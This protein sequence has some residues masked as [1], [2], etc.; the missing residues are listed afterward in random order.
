[1]STGHED[2]VNETFSELKPLHIAHS[3]AIWEAATTGT[4]EATERE[5]EAQGAMMRFW[6]D[7]T[8][9]NTADDLRLKERTEDALLARQIQLIYLS[10]AKAQQD[11]ETIEKITQL[12]SEVRQ[13]YYN[14]R[15]EV[16][17][18][19]LT[20]NE[21][22][23]ILKKSANSEDVRKA[24]E[25]GKQIGPKV[26]GQVRD[27]ARVRNQ[28][29]QRQGY[30][31]HFQKSLTLNEIDEDELMSLFDELEQVTR[32]PF[33]ELKDEIDERRAAHFGITKE[34]LNPWH[35]ADSFF[36]SPP[37]MG[38]I[39]FDTYFA[40]KDPSELGVK[41]YDGIG[42]EVRDILLRSDLFA[43]EGKDQ[44]AFCIDM[45]REGDIRTLNNLEPN[46]RWTRTLLHEL[47]HA[48]YDKYIDYDL[49]WILRRPAHSLSTEAVAILM[50]SLVNNR[51]WLERVLEVQDSDA[52]RISQFAMEH[53]RASRLIF[54]RWCLVM[55]HFER[56]FYGNPESDVDNLW[57]DLKERFQ[58]LR[59]PAGRDAPD[60]AA[61][62]HIA[63]VPVYYQN[64]E[65]GQLVSSQMEYFLT[66]EVGSLVENASAGKWLLDR[67]F[68]AGATEDWSDHVQSMTG[69]PLNPRYFIE[70]L[71]S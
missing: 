3:H 67:A 55:T 53:E 2:F 47:G 56:A 65:L 25:A 71:R 69:E 31:D 23:D 7:P 9:F 57:W 61:K 34:D 42:L 36:Q 39:D 27:L 45:D 12:E 26:S 58:L 70:S 5:K 14:F 49:P 40:D 68:R 37:P 21:L 8:R 16:N 17:G 44:S 54:T 59:R 6:A 10:A 60:W 4:E 11:E 19:Q 38:E 22:D 33:A 35:Y 28:A 24:W 18:K 63:L 66:M 51:E 52:E 46:R 50:G 41:T 29:S 13:A 20:N 32:T 64:Y 62:Y 15:A 48:V 30:R 43:R 1:M